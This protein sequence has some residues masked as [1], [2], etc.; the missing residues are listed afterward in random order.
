M[1]EGGEE[2]GDQSDAKDP[3]AGGVDVT[4]PQLQVRPWPLELEE[5]V[6]LEPAAAMNQMLVLKMFH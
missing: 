3:R 1:E 2:G 5:N 4:I 6:L